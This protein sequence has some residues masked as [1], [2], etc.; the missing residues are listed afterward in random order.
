MQGKEEAQDENWEMDL[1][2]IEHLKSQ[3]VRLRRERNFQYD[4]IVCGH[5]RRSSLKKEYE[6]EM[7]DSLKSNKSK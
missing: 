5:E 6:K 3:I 2:M 4:D 7:A 1:V